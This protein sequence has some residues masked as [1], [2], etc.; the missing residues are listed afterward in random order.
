MTSSKTDL[1]DTSD[2]FSVLGSW[3]SRILRMLDY[4]CP[5]IRDLRKPPFCHHHL[6]LSYDKMAIKWKP[7]LDFSDTQPNQ[8]SL[9]TSNS[10]I[11]IHIHTYSYHSLFPFVVPISVTPFRSPHFGH[12]GHH[13]TDLK[14]MGSMSEG[15]ICS[16]GAAASQASASALKRIFDLKKMDPETNGFMF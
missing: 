8:I 2:T 7:I 16:F 9:F 15:A 6:S 12:R 14:L 13:G 4:G 10:Y 1:F 3:C 11:F 5:K